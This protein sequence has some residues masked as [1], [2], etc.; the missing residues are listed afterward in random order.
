M[1]EPDA[2]LRARIVACLE[3]ERKAKGLS[4]EEFGHSLGLDRDG[5]RRFLGTGKRAHKSLD[6]YLTWKAAAVLGFRFQDLIAHPER[7][8]TPQLFDPRQDEPGLFPDELT[9]HLTKSH[10]FF[11][12]HRKIGMQAT[13][14]SVQDKVH[15]SLFGAISTT[16]RGDNI[17]RFYDKWTESA[18]KMYLASDPGDPIRLT[19]MLTDRDIAKFRT[20]K[21]PY[22]LCTP[23]EILAQ[24]HHFRVE[25]VQ[26][27]KFRLLSIDNEALERNK[28]LEFALRGVDSL[29][30]VG[31][32]FTATRNANHTITHSTM[33]ARVKVCRSELRRLER[34]AT[35][36]PLDKWE[37]E[38]ERLVRD[39]ERGDGP[40]VT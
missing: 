17:L 11:A 2:L 21:E 18:R 31:D 8:Q 29:C 30:V 7:P 39:Y 5:V 13:I 1:P 15:L 27:R 3:H 35:N 38:A 37:K 22:N 36:V 16:E 40:S 24:V 6:L 10:E 23:E 26:K 28:E 14:K 25:G 33:A 4:Q 32:G 19:Y 34:M 12:F 9:Y 20:R